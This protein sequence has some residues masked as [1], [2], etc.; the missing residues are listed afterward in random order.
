MTT[1]GFNQYI[2]G[3]IALNTDAT[4]KFA[5]YFGVDPQEIDPQWLGGANKGTD[6]EAKY[7]AILGLTTREQD[8]MAVKTIAART[9]SKDAITLARL[10]LDRVEAEL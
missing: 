9:S 7:E 4:Y 2:N 3:K 1:S 10:F 8:L 5:R 6:R